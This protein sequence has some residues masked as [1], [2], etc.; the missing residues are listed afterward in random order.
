ML[1]R[2]G[3]GDSECEGLGQA[4]YQQETTI[5]VCTPPER[6]CIEEE[7]R[8]IREV[9]QQYQIPSDVFVVI[10]SESIRIIDG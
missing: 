4:M 7:E 6:Q 5:I 9:L 1:D 3:A 10:D 8:R 2:D